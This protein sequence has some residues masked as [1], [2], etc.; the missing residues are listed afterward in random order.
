MTDDNPTR[1]AVRLLTGLDDDQLTDLGGFA[2]DTGT[3][4]LFLVPNEERVTVHRV[5]EFFEVLTAA[6]AMPPDPAEYFERPWKWDREYQTWREC[7]SPPV[8]DLIGEATG[9]TPKSIAWERFLR[10]LKEDDK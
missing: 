3:P 9:R 8:P 6:D 1:R 4:P 7:G 5:F 10:A 2:D